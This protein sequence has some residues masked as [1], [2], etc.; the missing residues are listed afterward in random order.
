LKWTA[1]FVKL[2]E[3]PEDKVSMKV[4][5]ERNEGITEGRISTRIKKIPVARNSDFLW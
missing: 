3:K 4:Q 1:E 5:C 2:E